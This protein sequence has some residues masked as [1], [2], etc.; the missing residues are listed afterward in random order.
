MQRPAFG[1]L[2]RKA[3]A[4]VEGQGQPWSCGYTEG[5]HSEAAGRAQAEAAQ[6]LKGTR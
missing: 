3:Q 6:D 1:G 4:G 5:Q 2:E